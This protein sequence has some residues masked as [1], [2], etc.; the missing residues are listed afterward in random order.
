MC[1]LN[2][3]LFSIYFTRVAYNSVQGSV[4]NFQGDFR[5][6]VPVKVMLVYGR[7]RN[8]YFFFLHLLS[9]FAEILCKGFEPNAVQPLTSFVKLGLAKA[10]LFL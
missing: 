9:T 3:A 8:S 7:T 10:E 6:I 1:K 2:F 4:K 5:E